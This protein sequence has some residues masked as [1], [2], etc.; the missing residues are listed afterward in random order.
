MGLGPGAASTSAACRLCCMQAHLAGNWQLAKI[1]LC[2]FAR[3]TVLE[4]YRVLF[5]CLSVVPVVRFDGRFRDQAY[6]QFSSLLSEIEIS[7]MMKKRITKRAL[8]FARFSKLSQ[9]RWS[10]AREA[11]EVSSDVTVVPCVDSEGGLTST[12]V[13]VD[14]DNVV[15]VG[16]V[17]DISCVTDVESDGLNNPSLASEKM[18]ND[19]S[20]CKKRS[21]LSLDGVDAE[22][23]VTCVS[24]SSDVTVVPCVDSE[25]GLTSTEVGIDSDNVMHVGPVSDISCVTDVESDGLNNPSLASEK[26]PNDGSPCKKRSKLSL[27]G[28]D[29]ESVVTCVSD[30]I[31]D[32]AEDDVPAFACREE[33]D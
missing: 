29:A 27:D 20:P 30:D 16:P 22:S 26:M 32:G 25:G 14:S 21:K 18:P 12:E 19:G 24:V 23:V 7:L 2:R 3:G 10:R 13:S 8:K 17:S 31:S 11:A 5:C 1:D 6:L 28:V 15:H 9:L 33:R 4:L